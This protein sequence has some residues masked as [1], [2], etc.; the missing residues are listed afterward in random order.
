M[1]ARNLFH[2]RFQAQI[3][4][5]SHR[6]G[7]AGIG[8]SPKCCKVGTNQEWRSS[9]K[10][11]FLE[12]YQQNSIQQNFGLIFVPKTTLLSNIRSEL[13]SVKTRE[14][15]SEG[16]QRKGLENRDKE[17]GSK[18]MTESYRSSSARAQGSQL[19]FQ[20]WRFRWGPPASNDPHQSVMLQ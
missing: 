4:T 1:E 9:P 19:L 12:G 15:K 11:E 16:S 13:H 7:S 5:F 10:R 6:R 3:E 18:G 2:G 8:T 20:S 17:E 14:V